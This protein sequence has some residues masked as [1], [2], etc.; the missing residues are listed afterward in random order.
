MF[1]NCNGMKLEIS[2]KEIWEITNMWKLNNTILNKQIS[3]EDN[4]REIRIC[5]KMSRN[6]NSTHQNLCNAA[7]AFQG[8]FV[9]VNDYLSKKSKNVCLHKNLYIN[10]QKQHYS[11]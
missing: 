8:N 5:I 7:K 4:H 6:K 2:Y 9:S 10:V 1:S 3:K 11:L